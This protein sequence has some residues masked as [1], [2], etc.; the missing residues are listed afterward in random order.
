MATIRGVSPIRSPTPPPTVTS[1][2][3]TA[4]MRASTGR[5]E[6]VEIERRDRDRGDR[7]EREQQRAAGD[8]EGPATDTH[9]TIVPPR[10]TALRGRESS[11]A[12]GRYASVALNAA[13]AALPG[14]S[15]ASDSVLSGTSTVF[16]A[17][18]RS[19]GIV[20]DVQQAGDDFALGAMRLEVGERAHLVVRVVLGVQ[21]AQ[22][23]HAAVVQHHVLR[24]RP[25][26]RRRRSARAAA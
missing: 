14:T 24:R 11:A 22:A 19:V 18:C 9:A 26:A 13:S 12:R 2:P 6:L 1:R 16:C 23:Q 5:D 7:H 8:P 3:V 20:L 4:L 25:P 17:S 21:L 10:E 15:S